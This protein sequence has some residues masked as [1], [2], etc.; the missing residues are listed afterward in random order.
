MT[1]ILRHH[2]LAY[3]ILALGFVLSLAAWYVAGV[4]TDPID[5]A[6]FFFNGDSAEVVERFVAADPYVRAGL[7][8]T[9]RVR[10]SAMGLLVSKTW[11]W[12]SWWP[13]GDMRG[14]VQARTT[15]GGAAQLRIMRLSAGWPQ[16][17]MLPFSAL[18][19][20]HLA[21]CD[22]CTSS[23]PSASRTYRP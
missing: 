23:G 15:H 5:A 19:I 10:R 4:L 14:P 16:S 18:A 7:V 21:S 22:M 17:E 8:I 12:A 20:V 11:T 9:W 6:V 13:V 2:R 3:V 1:R